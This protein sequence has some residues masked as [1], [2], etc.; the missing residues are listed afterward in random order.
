[1]NEKIRVST[2]ARMIDHSILH[3]T[4]SDIDLE[5]EC[6]LAKKYKVATVCV[7]PCHTKLASVALWTSDV[8]VCTV[9]GFPHGNSTIDIKLKEAQE[10]L[11]LGASEID[12]VVNIGKVLQKDWA[13]VER[14]ISEVNQVCVFNGAILKVIFETDFLPEDELK[15][16]LCEICNRVKVAFVKTS[17]GYGFKKNEA[18]TYFYDG[19]TDHDLELMREHCS[20]EVQIKAAGGIRT[21]DDVMRV[22]KLGVTRVGATATA[23]I[24]EEAKRFLK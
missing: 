21:F 5:R 19:A 22:R 17:T 18:G 12:M 7:K 13:Y 20:P 16:K 6:K 9:V 23:A 8:E 2:I 15:I 11:F 14:E 4:Y 10:A 1:M 3:P 24:L